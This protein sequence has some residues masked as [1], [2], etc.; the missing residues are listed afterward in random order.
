VLEILI[1][2]HFPTPSLDIDMRLFANDHTLP[3]NSRKRKREAHG[4]FCDDDDDSS[5]KIL[6]K[7]NSRIL[8][9]KLCVF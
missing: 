7:Y 4:L 6:D 8:R 1:R 2:R 5:G 9:H 3:G